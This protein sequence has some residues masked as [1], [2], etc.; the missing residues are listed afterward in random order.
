MNIGLRKSSL[1]HSAVPIAD[2]LAVLLAAIVV[3]V[4][5]STWIELNVSIVY[6]IP[7]VLLAVSRNRRLLW[8]LA[9][10]LVSTTFAV[11]PVQIAAGTFSFHEP[12]FINR[13]LAGITI[14]L[15][16]GLLHAWTLAVDTLDAQGRALKV[17]NGQL[18]AAQKEILEK[19]QELERRRAEAEQASRRKTRL[20]A[21]VS[22]D[23]RTPVSAISSI[24]QLMQRGLQDARLRDQLPGLAE[25]LRESALSLADLLSEVLDVSS[26]DSGRVSLSEREFCVNDL[27]AEACRRLR[28]LAQAKSLFLSSKAP[29]VP[30]W[31]RADETKLDRVLTNLINNAIKFT[32]EGS[33]S[34]SAGVMHDGTVMIRVSDTGPGIAPENLEK[35]FDEFEQLNQPRQ[36]TR[37]GWGLGLAICRHLVRL[38]GGRITVESELHHGTVFSVFL[39]PERVLS[40]P[41]G[42][43]A[44]AE[45]P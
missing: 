45:S 28:P 25:D 37:Q 16:A 8:A 19:N 2:L 9:T 30:R 15:T 41:P 21:T 42:A 17:Q 4:D 14:V 29:D 22:H 38:I 39:P 6:G 20:L 5:W 7:L 23:I 34:V 11:Y 13:V 12:M 27:L 44:R 3:F 18:E 36:N 26:F 31:L 10:V 35:I 1:T 32:E 40:K 43:L 24:A 33:V